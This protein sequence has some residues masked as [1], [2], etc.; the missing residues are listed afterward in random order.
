[1][2]LFVVI[3]ASLAWLLGLAQADLTASQVCFYA[4]QQTYTNITFSTYAETDDYYTG[5]CEN[6]LLLLSTFLCAKVYCTSEETVSG[7][8]YVTDLCTTYT[9][10]EVLSYDALEANTSH[11]SIKSV[12]LVE[13]EPLNDTLIVDTL[14][15][16]S[17]ELFDY[18]YQ[19]W[20]GHSAHSLHLRSW[21]R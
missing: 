15:L 20:V 19:L 13:L 6:N 12:P 18:S 10:V 21:L 3:L 11:V 2:V 9:S 1:M 16:P 8:A 17:T 4:C 7:L 5:Y 14:M